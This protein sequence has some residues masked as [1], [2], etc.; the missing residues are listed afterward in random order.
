M[1]DQQL[2][3]GRQARVYGWIW[4]GQRVANLRALSHVRGGER[5]RSAGGGLRKRDEIGPSKTGIDIPLEK[6]QPMRES[7]K[8]PDRHGDRCIQG[9]TRQESRD[10]ATAESGTS[11]GLQS[12]DWTEGSMTR[13]G[14]PRHPSCILPR[15]S[16]L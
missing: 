9:E 13:L 12:G 15:A 5:V 11:A 14:Y 16:G 1:I 8:A 6:V 10:D 2:T 7:T 3:V 4:I